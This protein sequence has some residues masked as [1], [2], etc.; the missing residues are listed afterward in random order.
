M[1]VDL[2]LEGGRRGRGRCSDGRGLGRVG[3]AGSELLLRMLRSN[4]LG[5]D[6]TWLPG[7]QSHR[8]LKL[9]QEG[10]TE[11]SNMGLGGAKEQN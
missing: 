11:F 3:R 4:A 1:R 6:W 7:A 5:R 10:Q 2:P 8:T 9:L